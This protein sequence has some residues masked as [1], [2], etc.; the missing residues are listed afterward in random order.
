MKRSKITHCLRWLVLAFACLGASNTFLATPAQ[1][2]VQSEYSNVAFPVVTLTGPATSSP[3]QLSPSVSGANG[4][5]NSATVDVEGTFTSVTFEVMVSSNSGATYYPAAVNALAS[6]SVVATS[7]TSTASGL[8]QIPLAGI[9]N[10]EFIVTS[11]TGTNVKFALT[12][13]P[14]GLISKV[15]GYAT[16]LQGYLIST[17]APT[18]GQGLVWNGSVYVPTV[19]VAITV[20]TNTI[21]ANECG[22][23]THPI[24]PVG[25][26][27][28]SGGTL[29]PATS[30]YMKLAALDA[31]GDTTSSSP[32]ATTTTAAQLATPVAPVG[33]GSTTGGT[34][35]AAS[36]Y[37]KIAA[38]DSVGNTTIASAEAA[39]VTTTG[40]TSSISYAFTA[41]TGAVSYNLYIGTAAAGENEVIT[42]ITAT[43]YVLTAYTAGVAVPP[44][45]NTSNT[46]SSISYAFTAVTGASSYNLY[47]GTAAGAENEVVTGI[48]V[49]PYVLAAFTAGVAVAPTVNMTLAQVTMPN[50]TTGM[51]I[52]ISPASDTRLVTGFG[53]SGASLY[54]TAWPSAA[55]TARYSMCNATGAS[56]T[57]SAATTWN[58]SAR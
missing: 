58:G 30:Y 26:A 21:S 51:T 43:P 54:F 34:L 10:V 27:V 4:S 16:S 33:T 36:Y 35:A 13:S 20:A 15:G 1:A 11:F 31:Y 22:I 9:T 32:E 28:L 17:I 14:N 41:V 40:T 47:V 6:T 37:V 24:L 38:V 56:I 46:T 8:Y 2:A 42:G 39:A 19:D 48:T 18:S 55:N 12:A 29:L 49:T 57:P 53:P 25:T 5:F 44:T 52:T 45:T 7:I 50:L 3:I 23:F